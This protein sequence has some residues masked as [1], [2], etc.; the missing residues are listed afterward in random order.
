MPTHLHPRRIPNHKVKA[1]VPASTVAQAPQEKQAPSGENAARRPAHERYQTMAQRWQAARHRGA[2]P[3]RQQPDHRG[4]SRA[5]AEQLEPSRMGA[6][7]PRSKRAAARNASRLGR[8][9][10]P[11]RGQN[12]KTPRIHKQLDALKRAGRRL[13]VGLHSLL[14]SQVGPGASGSSKLN[15]E[16]A[17]DAK[18]VAKELSLS[19]SLCFSSCP[20]CLCGSDCPTPLPCAALPIHSIQDQSSTNH[21]I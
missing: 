11:T 12:H 16:G 3:Q 1:T 15:R 6:S 5:G 9:S 10:T 21:R 7:S 20:S 13:Q 8:C 4:G 17:K 2:R 14:L 18:F 19:S